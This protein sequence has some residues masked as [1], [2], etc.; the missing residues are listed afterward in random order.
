MDLPRLA[1]AKRLATILVFLA[2]C[3]ADG[4]LS[5]VVFGVLGGSNGGG[6]QSAGPW[7]FLLVVLVLATLDALGVFLIQM[8]RL[9]PRVE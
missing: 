6:Q 9:R 4:I 7:G 8:D 5:L 2:L 1:R 3:I